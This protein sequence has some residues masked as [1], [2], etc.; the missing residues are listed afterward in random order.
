[1]RYALALCLLLATPAAAGGL[2]DVA[3]A[4]EPCPPMALANDGSMT[5]Q[6]FRQWVAVRQ[7]SCPAPRAFFDRA[8]GERLTDAEILERVFNGSGPAVVP[9]PGSAW[10]LLAGLGALAWRRS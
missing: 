4:P 5:A 9:L 2:D 3:Q 8:T 1:M 7:M 6:M 10:L